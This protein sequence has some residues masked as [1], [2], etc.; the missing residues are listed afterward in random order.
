MLFR[1]V[2]GFVVS[3][4]MF[5][6]IPE[7]RKDQQ[8]MRF[9][10]ESN[11]EVKDVMFVEEHLTGFHTLQLILESDGN[12][13]KKAA[14]WNKVFALERKLKEL[15]EVVATDSLLP[16]LVHA[17]SLLGRQTSS[18]EELFGNPDLIPQLLF[19][20]TLS[21]DGKRML[22][23]YVEDG[24]NRIRIIVRFRN[25]PSAS[26]E[27][28]ANQIRTLADSVMDGAA[29]SVVTGELAVFAAQGGDFVRSEIYSMIL[30]LGIITIL[31]MIQMG[32]PLFGLISLIPNIPP[33]AAVFGVMGWFGIALD[34]ATI[35]AAT[36]AVGLA[37]DNT[38]Q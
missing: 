21:P 16:Y 19:L 27:E 17:H 34:G 11:S 13:F 37:V 4:A 14:T 15:P 18:P 5:S 22:R 9:L 33:I 29:K 8:F 25:S 24:Y 2:A 38:I 7:I 36:V 12:A 6:G 32:T 26:V 23:R 3:A 31:M 1:S 10:G 20:T 35:F 28:T 30:A